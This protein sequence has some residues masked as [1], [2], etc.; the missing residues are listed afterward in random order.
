MD[1]GPEMRTKYLD[2][3][4]TKKTVVMLDAVNSSKQN[5]LLS[6]LSILNS[7]LI[8]VD[9]QNYFLDPDSHA[10]IPSAPT[11]LQN[12]ERIIELFRVKNRPVFFT[13]HHNSLDN[14][15]SMT[16]WWRDVLGK[17][18]YEWELVDRLTANDDEIIDKT[19]YDIFLGTGLEERLR[20]RL[21]SDI[22][23]VGVHTHLCCETSARAAF[24]RNF[25][26]IFPVD[27]TATYNPQHHQSTLL[28]LT[29]GFAATPSLD[30]LTAV[31][32]GN[33][34]GS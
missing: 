10:F 8:V 23:I 21:V 25:S 14:P 20:N 19:T 34:H 15:G 17:N 29:H 3:S 28:N 24:T 5:R 12:I 4:F 33:Y 26:V 11:V 32:S 16:R 30:K 22:V 1:V 2:D 31:L 18:S 6:K 27:G 7:A 9:M 13:R